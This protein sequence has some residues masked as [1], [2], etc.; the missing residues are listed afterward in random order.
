FPAAMIT[1]KCAP[2]L[3]AGCPVLIKPAEQTPLTAIALAELAQEAGFPDGLISVLTGDPAR[4][5]AAL[6]ESPVVRKLS[7]TGSTE[8]GK[9]LM[10]ACADTVKRVSFE[11]GGHAPLLVFDDADL[12]AAV[13]GAVA[14]KFRN[15][16]Q[17]CVCANRIFVQ[18]GVYDEFARRLTAKVAALKV[19]PGLE[20]GVEQGPLID[21]AAVAKVEAHVADAIAGGATALCGGARHPRGGTFYQPTVLKDVRSDMLIAREETFGPVAPLLRFDDEAE[22][23]RLANDTPY[24]LASYLFTRDLGR[25]FRVSEALEYGMV[26]VNSG[27]LST[28]EAPFG[29]VKQSGIGREGSRHGIDE[30]LEIKYTLMRGI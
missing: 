10:R 16:G 15:A 13:A 20:E 14:S 27:A 26:A 9:L 19:G 11:L 29:G 4:I 25:A 8:V 12:D 17:T 7:F 21:E 18:A 5:G 30:Y 22:G 2:A 3:A 6:T 23:V 28:V 1:R 24:G